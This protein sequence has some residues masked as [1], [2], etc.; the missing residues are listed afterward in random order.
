MAIIQSPFD[1]GDQ[2]TI[3]RTVDTVIFLLQTIVVE[4]FR[5]IVCGCKQLIDQRFLREF[6]LQLAS[7]FLIPRDGQRESSA[8]AVS[9]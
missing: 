9:K 8:G 7:R 1:L 3:A 6:E 4:T 5:Q 2:L